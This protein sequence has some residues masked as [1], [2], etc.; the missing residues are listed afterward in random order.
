MFDGCGLEIRDRLMTDLSEDPRFA[1]AIETFNRGEFLEAAD[2]FE[3]LFFEAV[4]D[5]V[6]VVRTLMQLSVGCLH[7]ERRQK[8]AAVGR[9]REGLRAIEAVT[10]PHGIAFAEL[11]RETL[12]AIEAI[13]TG[14]V[15]VWPLVKA[16]REEGTSEGG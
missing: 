16:R 12:A 10:E 4:R 11:R 2:A 7:A 5:E 3:E 13:E 9:L 1:S 8:S 6:A 14:R 15:P